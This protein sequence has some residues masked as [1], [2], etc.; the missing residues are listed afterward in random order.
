MR[1]MP[2]LCIGG[3]EIANVARVTTYGSGEFFDACPCPALDEETFVGVAE[4]PAPWYD[5]DHPESVDFLGFLPESIT[6]SSPAGRTSVPVRNI[7]SFVG[8]EGLRG[9]VIEVVGWMVARDLPAMW[10]GERWLIEALRGDRCQGCANDVLT[11]LPFCRETGSSLD[12][13]AD[14][15]TLVRAALVDGPRFAE[16]SDSP[17]FV[18]GTVQ[19][20][21]VASM[22]YLYHPADRCLDEEAAGSGEL[23][24]GLT[25]PDLTED[26]TFVIDIS[27][28][29]TVDAT[30]IT[31]TGQVSLDGSCP[32]TGL[33]TSVPPSFVYEIPVLAPE[34][35]IVIDGTRRQAL[36]YDASAKRASSAIPYITFEGPFRWPDVGACQTMCLSIT[37]AGGDAVATVDAHLRSL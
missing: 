12:Y 13:D 7:G 22:P 21:L 16:L 6:L 30:D 24:C 32:V 17:D 8:P 4:D 36:Y 10:Y 15:R 3:T 31:I 34:D 5:A 35:R 2:F 28:V 23:S 20:Q 18:V 14:F 29:D 26:G 27:N 1:L 11:V 9:R 25:T 33:G 37:S 19:F